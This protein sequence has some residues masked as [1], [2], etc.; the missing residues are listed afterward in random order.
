MGRGV[1]EKRTKSSPGHRAPRKLRS[2]IDMARGFEV[3][4]SHVAPIFEAGA[5]IVNVSFV[6][7][8][9]EEDNGAVKIG[10]GVNPIKR[11]RE[12]QVGNP[13]RMRVERLLLGDRSLEKLL[14]EYWDRFAIVSSSK[15]GRS[16]CGPGTEWFKPEIRAELYPIV[17]IAASQ[18][19]EALLYEREGEGPEFGFD[20]LVAIVKEAHA[21]HDFVL[22]Q[23]D[24]VRLMARGAG[25]VTRR[26]HDPRF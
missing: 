21:D 2:P 12:M 8:I 19:I 9:G 24:E 1:L 5:P 18:Q 20:D 26:L 14:H 3:E 25:T 11:L 17:E 13:R 16:D 6:Y 15:R 10:V 7:C 22:R 4:W 23:E